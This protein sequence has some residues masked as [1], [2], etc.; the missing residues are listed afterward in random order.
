MPHHL[1]LVVT[2]E[3]VLNPLPGVHLGPPD[4]SLQV[5]SCSTVQL[6]VT[7]PESLV[8]LPQQALIL[9]GHPWFLIWIHLDA[10]IHS[11]SIC[12]VFDVA[13][14]CYCVHL[15]VWVI[16][17]IPVSSLKT[18]LKL[19]EAPSGQVLTVLVVRT[20]FLRGVY[21]GARIRDKWSDRPRCGSCIAL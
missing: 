20:R 15:Q 1:P 8:F 14:N 7:I 10:F 6:H 9:F 2:A 12:T 19:G 5:G 16:E 21:A 17:N 13:Q 18:V 11:N 3:V 4:A